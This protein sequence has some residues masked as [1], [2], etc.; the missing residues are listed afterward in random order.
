MP[1]SLTIDDKHTLR[2]SRQ[3]EGGASES[4][5]ESVRDHPKK[6]VSCSN[7]SSHQAL[8]FRAMG[9]Q[10]R[11]RLLKAF[12][13]VNDQCFEGLNYSKCSLSNRI[14]TY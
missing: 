12:L 10:E 4:D 1:K 6:V 8:S 11:E 14:C 3:E 2:S 5:G 13:I 7:F 9:Q